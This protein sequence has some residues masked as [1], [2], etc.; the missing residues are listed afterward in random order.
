M[1]K[2]TIA[3]IT[4]PI[5]LAGAAAFAS[6]H[7][8]DD[9]EKC[10][11]GHGHGHEDRMHKSDK[12]DRAERMVERMSKRL[13]LSDEQ[14]V[15]MKKLFNDKQEQHQTMRTEMQNF[16][17]ATRNLDPNAADYDKSLAEA[18]RIA[19][20]LAVKKVDQKVSMKAELSKILTAEQLS[21][22]E[23]M[24]ERHGEGH[25]K[26]HGYKHGDK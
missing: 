5:L 16:H 14:Q 13:E 4:A 20:D 15:A 23:D 3:M 17:Q 2:L 9:N 10:D 11:R 19:A 25:G 24:R 18:K 8:N 12:G 6:M 1:K 7:N 22:F 26:K 21:K